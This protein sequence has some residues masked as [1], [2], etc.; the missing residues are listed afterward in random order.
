MNTLQLIN[1]IKN[2]KGKDFTLSL[3]Q[4]YGNNPIL[5]NISTLIQENRTDEIETIAR[6]FAKEKGIDYDKE[7]INFKNMLGIK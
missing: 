2:G 5:S 3:L 1:M 6:N 7:F 4:Q